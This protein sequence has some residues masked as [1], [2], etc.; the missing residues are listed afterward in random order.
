MIITGEISNHMEDQPAEGRFPNNPL[1]RRTLGQDLWAIRIGD[2]LFSLVLRY[3][4]MEIIY[5][6]GFFPFDARKPSPRA[7]SH[8]DRAE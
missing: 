8:V 7:D 6:S 4:F 2:T 1:P 5:S 3:I